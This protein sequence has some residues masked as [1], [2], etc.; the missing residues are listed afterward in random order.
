MKTKLLLSFLTIS[1]MANAQWQNM[2]PVS[3][4][5]NC[6]AATGTNVYAG[7]A[8]G[9]V[10]GSIDSGNSW[11][12]CCYNGMSYPYIWSIMIDG[13]NVFAATGSGVYLSTDSA[14]NWTPIS[15]GLTATSPFDTT[16]L[17]LLKSGTN[18]FAGTSGQGIYFSSNYGSS[19]NAVNNGLTN[20]NARALATDGVNIFAGT[21][22]GGVF[23]STNNGGNWNAINNGLT[24]GNISSI[25][26]EGGNIYVGTSGG[27]IFLST[28]NGSNWVAINNGLL[29]LNIT[30]FAISGG[31]I[32]AGTSGGGVYLSTN[33]GNNWTS[34][35]NGLTNSNISGLSISGTNIF[36]SIY[37]G[38]VWRRSL[39]EVV[40]INELIAQNNFRIFPNPF[41]SMTTIHSDIIFKDATLTI[42]NSLG[43]EVKMLKNIFGQSITIQRD[44]LPI[45]LYSIRV[46]QNN[47]L[48][49]TD[50]LII[51][52]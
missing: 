24:N 33:N 50:K 26:I 5:M 46:T 38:G 52:D 32:F 23:L 48:I 13:T 37:M 17:S 41:S 34:I 43:Q 36:A 12:T 2:N 16:V 18:L 49:A 3:P 25:A 31:N 42:Y 14:A 44:N 1:C 22:G 47:K 10:E 20:Q 15:N 8:G 28:N 6:V 11:T 39:S 51:A 40:G 7:R 30:A 9:G 27:G 45:G 4:Q 35:N 19:W 21:S 29:N